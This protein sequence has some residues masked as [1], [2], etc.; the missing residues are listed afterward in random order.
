[1]EVEGKQIDDEDR[2]SDWRMEIKTRHRAPSCNHFFLSGRI[3]Q[4]WQSGAFAKLLFLLLPHCLQ[5][6]AA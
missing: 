2:E 6:D 3:S 1:M 5:G 4:K